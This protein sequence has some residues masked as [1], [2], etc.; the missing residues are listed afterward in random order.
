MDYNNLRRGRVNNESKI[1]KFICEVFSR[2]WDMGSYCIC[3][4]NRLVMS[5]WYFMW[6]LS[7]IILISDWNG[8]L[9]PTVKKWEQKLGIPVFYEEVSDST[10][11]IS[12]PYPIQYVP[13]QDTFNSQRE[14]NESGS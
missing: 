4:R 2:I 7:T 11:H 12:N 8:R 6:G 1:W 10:N 3:I 14:N 5:W 13:Q 9:E